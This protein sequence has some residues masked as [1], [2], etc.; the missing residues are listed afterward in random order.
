MAGTAPA[1]SLDH[2]VFSVN[3]TVR[4]GLMAAHQPSGV[5]PIGPAAADHQGFPAVAS[6]LLA[7]GTPRLRVV[8]A[9]SSFRY[10]DRVTGV[11]AGWNDGAARQAV[12]EFVERTGV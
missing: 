5:K 6:G 2:A 11:L 7:D 9:A 12:V 1:L 3:A 10:A 8:V 4:A